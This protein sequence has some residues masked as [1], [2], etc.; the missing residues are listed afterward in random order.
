MAEGFVSW[1]ERYGHKS[2]DWVYDPE[3]VRAAMARRTVLNTDRRAAIKSN[4]GSAARAELARAA[5]EDAR[6]AD[7]V[8]RAKDFLAGKLRCAIFNAETDGGPKGMIVVG[9]KLYARDELLE[10]ARAKGWRDDAPPVTAPRVVPVPPAPPKPAA[11]P[12]PP[13]AALPAPTTPSM[14]PAPPEPPRAAVQAPPAPASPP[15]AAPP[16]PVPNITPPQSNQEE[17]AV[18][19]FRNVSVHFKGAALAALEALAHERDVPYATAARELIERAIEQRSATPADPYDHADGSRE[20]RPVDPIKP[21][22]LPIEQIATEAL[23]A[24]LRRRIEAADEE[25]LGEAIARAE[26]AEA[27]LARLR[28]ALAA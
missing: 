23:L 25:A 9:R 11:P 22:P 19:D 1:A 18:A 15:H 8:E 16:V 24:E 20:C 28:E 27:R 4:V 21:A 17:K 14:P 13:R 12:K 10:F 3:K 6:R 5:A 2:R 26:A 7:P